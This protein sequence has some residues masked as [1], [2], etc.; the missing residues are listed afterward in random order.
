MSCRSYIDLE[1][2]DSFPSA[3][4]MALFLTM[5]EPAEQEKLLE[6]MREVFDE[7]KHSSKNS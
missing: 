4:T 1:H 6:K 3:T 5:L 7:I 2:G